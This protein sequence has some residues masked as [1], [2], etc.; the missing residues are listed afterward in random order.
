MGFFGGNGGK[1]GFMR[2]VKVV[3]ES[4]TRPDG[5]AEAGVFVGEGAA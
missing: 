4:L 3:V 2:T 1:I 5:R